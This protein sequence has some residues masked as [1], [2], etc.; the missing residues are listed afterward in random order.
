MLLIPA[1]ICVFVAGHYFLSGSRSG[2]QVTDCTCLYFP[3]ACVM[4]AL[5]G[6]DSVCPECRMPSWVRDVRPDRQMDTLIR[7]IHTMRGTV[8]GTVTGLPRLSL[9]SKTKQYMYSHASHSYYSPP[10]MRTPP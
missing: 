8:G 1:L 10:D 6:R 7:L 5:T 4:D 3:R 9:T 2:V